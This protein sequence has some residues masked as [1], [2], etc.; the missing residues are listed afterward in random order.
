MP[1][2][3]LLGGAL[4]PD[5]W[6]RAVA[7]VLDGGPAVHPVPADR[8]THPPEPDE[9]VAGA[10]VVLTTSGSTGT[11]RHVVLDRE[12]LLA[13]ARGTLD[14]LGGPGQWLQTLSPAQVAGWQVW[15]RSV[16]A[17][18]PPVVMPR[19]AGFTVGAFVEGTARLRPGRPHYT[20]LVP[21]QLHR[22]LADPA[23]AQALRSYDTVLVGG[24]ALSP[25]LHAQVRMHGIRVRTTYGMTETSGGC[26]YDGAPLGE[27]SVDL[28]EQGRILLAGPVLARGYLG[29]RPGTRSAFHVRDGRRWFRTSDLG[30]RSADG[31]WSVLGRVDDVIN[32]GAHK[33]LPATVEAA[34]DR[35][36]EVGGSLVVGTPD[37]QW[38][39]RVAA[40]VVPTSAAPEGLRREPTRWVREHL[41]DGIPAHALPREVRLVTA[42]PL[43]PGG[44][45]DRRA[46][47]RLLPGVDGTL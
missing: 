8:T 38:G 19:R 12:A 20:S 31:T 13:S 40:L 9:L 47:R 32:T 26:V 2:L 28:D 45:V 24:A 10:A 14:R 35:L 5:R 21:T 6:W 37:P 30:R 3:L 27:V 11:P 23:G 43:L 22:L 4:T 44:K 17:G 33:V 18:L 16:V 15:V 41:R 39:Q 34:L 1:P 42:L 36:P 25:V 29:D 46:A 7:D